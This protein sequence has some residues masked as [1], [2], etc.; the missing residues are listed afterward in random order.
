[1]KSFFKFLLVLTIIGAGV[2]VT[3]TLI[4][5]KPAAKKKSVSIGIPIVETVLAISGNKQIYIDA[6]GT[7]I[8]ACQITLQPQVSGMVI[9]VS[10][11][12]VPGG[13]FLKNDVILKLDNRDY[14]INQERKKADIER[15]VV[16][17]KTEKGKQS[18]AMRE[19]KLLGSNISTTKEGRELALRKPHIERAK[20]VLASARSGLESARLDLERTTLKAPFNAFIKEKFIDIGQHTG[21]GTRLATL[22][23]I[24]SFHVIISVPVE[25]LSLI[26]IPKLNSETGSSA[27]III[28]GNG[29]G[30]D[31]SREGSV[32]RLMGN[33]DPTGRMARLLIDVKNPLEISNDAPIP[34]LLDTYVKVKIKGPLLEQVFSIP[35]RAL[36][37]GSRVW[38]AGHDNLLH[39]KK[40]E[41]I[42]KRKNDVLLK[43]LESRDRIIT[44]RIAAPVENMKIEI[45][46]Q[47]PESVR[48]IKPLR[49]D[50]EN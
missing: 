29:T 49:Q 34:L 4:K 48:E 38:T 1:M 46:S 23:G 24:D 14:L 16:E 43:G 41:V 30:I 9:F 22:V 5:T 3:V 8:P 36:R 47:F 15:A 28:E 33:L 19:W 35:R 13:R 37:P 45:A 20:A 6:M 11:E 50:G 31:T 26:S 21:P 44:S 12:W 25:K 27:T 10:P 40:V 42:W 7:V 18:I 32:I 39:I 2:L 17:L